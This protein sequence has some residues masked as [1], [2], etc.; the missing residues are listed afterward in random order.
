MFDKDDD[1]VITTMEVHTI[2]KSIGRDPT[3]DEV[4]EA[5]KPFDADGEEKQRV[6]GQKKKSQRAGKQQMTA[7]AKVRG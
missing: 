2:L 5:M 6:E 7:W 3:S 1:G 4:R